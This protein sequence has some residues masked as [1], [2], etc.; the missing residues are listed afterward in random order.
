MNDVGLMWIILERWLKVLEF[1][2]FFLIFI[3]FQWWIYN[4]KRLFKNMFDDL[5]KKQFF[6]FMYKFALAYLK[7]LLEM[8]NHAY[9]NIEIFGKRI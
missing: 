6:F 3:L 7:G 1:F 8:K 4:D 2:I 9:K 5:K